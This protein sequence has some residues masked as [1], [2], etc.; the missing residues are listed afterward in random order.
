MKEDVKLLLDLIDECRDLVHSAMRSWPY[1]G[2]LKHFESLLDDAYLAA[3]R[4]GAAVGQTGGR[5]AEITRP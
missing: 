3:S 5:N 4:L 1:R 2:T